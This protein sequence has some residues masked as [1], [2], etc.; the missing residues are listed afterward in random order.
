[1]LLSELDR[2]DRR[3]LIELDQDASAS[4]SQI[5]R[6]IRIGNDLVEYRMQRFFKAGVINRLTPTIN[7][8][9]LGFNVFKTYLKHRIPQKLKKTWIKTIDQHPNTYWLVEGYGR[10]D[11]LISIAARDFTEFQKILDTHIGNLGEHFIDLAVFPLVQVSRFDKKYLFSDIKINSRKKTNWENASNKVLLD[12][13]GRKILWELSD[14]CRISDTEL[15]LRLKVTPAMISYRRK[16]FLDNQVIVGYRLQFD[17]SVLG[18]IF[19]KVFLELKDYSQASRITIR[20]FCE[21]EPE[22]TCFAQQLGTYSLEFEAELAGYQELN[23][24]MDRFRDNFSSL[25]AKMEYM[26]ITKDYYHRVPKI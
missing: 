5:A 25:I 4:L 3:I 14:N 20:D 26:V 1:M 9:V 13:L 11:I 18:M 22:I 2:L 6:K 24:L 15:A 8:S 7:P 10:W 23:K 21:S 16:A 12:D 19:V 17:Y